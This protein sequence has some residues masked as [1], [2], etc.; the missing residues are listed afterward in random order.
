MEPST[1][2]MTLG[3][4]VPQ[5][6]AASILSALH[7]LMA[8]TRA[9]RGCT[10]CSLSSQIGDYTEIRCVADWESE[11]DLQRQ[12][13]SSDF[14]QLAELLE[15]AVEPPTIEFR[16]PSGMQGLEYAERVRRRAHAS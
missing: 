10:G 14:T 12:I 9:G 16:L 5:R 3:W 2:R 13:L 7:R 15:R 8:R 11:E 4:R 6:E 1:V